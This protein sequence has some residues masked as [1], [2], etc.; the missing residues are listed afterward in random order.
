MSQNGLK[1][2][3][4]MFF[5]SVTNTDLDPPIYNKCCTFLRLPIF[6]LVLRHPVLFM[7]IF[8]LPPFSN[9]RVIFVNQKLFKLLYATASKRKASYNLSG[10]IIRIKLLRFLGG[11][12]IVLSL[13]L[14]TSLIILDLCHCRF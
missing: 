12:D 2:I 14:I 13:L 10:N 11:S 3:S 7:L 4:N 9:Y 6:T 8:E 5:K 1:H